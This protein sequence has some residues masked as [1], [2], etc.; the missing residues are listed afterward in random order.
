MVIS[1]S[2][3]YVIE[4][5]N[6][7][8]KILGSRRA[9]YWRAVYP[10]G[11]EFEFFNPIN[12]NDS[13][14]SALSYTLRNILSGDR[15]RWFKSVIVFSDDANIDKVSH[16]DKGLMVLNLY[17]TSEAIDESIEHFKR[18]SARKSLSPNAMKSIYDTL[19]PYANAT[20]EQVAQH[21]KNVNRR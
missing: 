18:R 21:A 1:E 16:R 8:A 9:E 2:G 17:D 19:Y 11:R 6:Y 4:S 20:K 14:I 7:S 15:D 12:Q 13:H 10:N 5:K 3:I